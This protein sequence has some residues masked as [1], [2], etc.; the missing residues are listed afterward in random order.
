MFPELDHRCNNII[1]AQIF[2]VYRLFLGLSLGDPKVGDLSIICAVCVLSHLVLSDSL[3]PFGLQLA[4]L[5]CLWDFQ[6][7]ILEWVAI[8]LL[9]GIFLTQGSNLNLQCLLHRRWILY[10]LS[11][12]GSPYTQFQKQEE[13]FFFGISF[14]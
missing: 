8:F 2:S 13:S 6:P 12:W 9:Q 11:Y 4:R 10:S 3:R 14:Y 5:L 7:R 1:Q